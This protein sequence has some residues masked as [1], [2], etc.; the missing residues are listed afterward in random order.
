[1]NISAVERNLLDDFS[2]YDGTEYGEY[3]GAL[4]SFHDMVSNMMSESLRNEVIKELK[5]SYADITQNLVRRE[6][7]EMAP[8]KT[9][10]YESK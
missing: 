8:I 9:C 4:L 3:V 7:V 5:I 2:M 10:W 6:E 1:M